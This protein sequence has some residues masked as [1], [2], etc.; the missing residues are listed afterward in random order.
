[1]PGDPNQE[2]VCSACHEY[3]AGL[4]ENFERMGIPIH[5]CERATT[6]ILDARG[7]ACPC[8]CTMRPIGVIQRDKDLYGEFRLDEKGG[9]LSVVGERMKERE[10]KEASTTTLSPERLTARV[11]ALEERMTAL[12]ESIAEHIADLDGRA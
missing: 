9:V 10:Q 8:G 12:E 3:R 4:R 7:D 11:A 2:A 5:T 6:M 1:M